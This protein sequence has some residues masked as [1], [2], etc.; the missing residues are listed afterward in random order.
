MRI[1]VLIEENRADEAAIVLETVGFVADEGAPLEA[2]DGLL[3]VP[4]EM[5][6]KGLRELQAI[7]GVLDWKAAPLEEAARGDRWPWDQNPETD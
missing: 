2:Q 4:G 6:E 1:I 7:A 5:P 3:Q